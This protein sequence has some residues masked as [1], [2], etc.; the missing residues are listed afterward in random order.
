MAGTAIQIG[1]SVLPWSQQTLAFRNPRPGKATIVNHSAKGA[2]VDAAQARARTHVHDAA[3]A[4]G[5]PPD[6]HLVDEAVQ[7]AL[8]GGFDALNF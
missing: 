4:T 3:G 2:A 7:Q 1:A 6:G 5:P 8:G